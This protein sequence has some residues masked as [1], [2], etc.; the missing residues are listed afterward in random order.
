MSDDVRRERVEES[1]L[2]LMVEQ[3]PL[4][5][6]NRSG[7]AFPSMCELA[8][9]RSRRDDSRRKGR[10]TTLEVKSVLLQFHSKSIEL[11]LQ[12]IDDDSLEVT[13][14]SLRPLASR[15]ENNKAWVAIEECPE[16]REVEE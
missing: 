13:E 5:V 9:S 4:V 1:S 15:Y 3:T 12:R 11:V 16:R 7:L 14:F 6:L 2:L 10:G 8:Q